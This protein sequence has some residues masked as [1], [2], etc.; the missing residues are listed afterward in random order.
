VV[1]FGT[2]T[3]PYFEVERFVVRAA[4]GL[5]V[6]DGILTRTDGA[7]SI[8]L[9]EGGSAPLMNPSTDLHAAAG[10]RIWITQTRPGVGY[11]W[12]RIR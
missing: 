8:A 7:F 11:T 1:V 10:T 3:D 12:G 9:T 5:P 4:D 6:W 2:S